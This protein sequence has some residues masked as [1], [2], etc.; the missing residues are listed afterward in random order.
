MTPSRDRNILIWGPQML[1]IHQNNSEKRKGSEMIV[2]LISMAGVVC[3]AV[4][5]HS[6][7]RV[8]VR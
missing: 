2:V 1:L 3:V 4:E 7:V 5:G 6:R 8:Y